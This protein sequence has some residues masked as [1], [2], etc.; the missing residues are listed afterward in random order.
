[1]SKFQQQ[2][3]EAIAQVIQGVKEDCTPPGM[4]DYT[5]RHMSV[6]SVIDHIIACLSAEFKHDNR[7]FDSSRFARACE[8][9][10]NI[11]A[12]S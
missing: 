2:H 4:K 12:R 9:G 8:H 1:M 11:K 5:G 3:Y 10:A 6:E 7:M